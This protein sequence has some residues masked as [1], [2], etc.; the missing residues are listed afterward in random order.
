MLYNSFPVS[1]ITF[2]DLKPKLNLQ[3]ISP[4]ESLANTFECK[5][6]KVFTAAILLNTSE[7]LL[8]NIKGPYKMLISKLF[9]NPLVAA[10]ETF[11]TD[12]TYHRLN[13]YFFAE[14]FVNVPLLN[15]F[16]IR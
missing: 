2:A 3:F 16:G 4:I 14:L 8:L 9:T 5:I 6:S 15:S 13:W 10:P 1:F 12:K 7:W 11:S